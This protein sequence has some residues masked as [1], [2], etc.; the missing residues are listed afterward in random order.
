MLKSLRRHKKTQ[1]RAVDFVNNRRTD[2]QCAMLGALG[3]S[4]GF[5]ETKTGLSSGQIQYR[6]R[7][8]SI[9]RKEFRNGTSPFAKML[10]GHAKEVAA[11]RLEHHLRTHVTSSHAAYRAAA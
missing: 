2:Y 8:A 9:S 3:F 10:I 6:L 7:T 4:T 1:P 5:I 11:P